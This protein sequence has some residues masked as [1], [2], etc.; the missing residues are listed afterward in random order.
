MTVRW[1]VSSLREVPSTA[2]RRTRL[3]LAALGIGL[4]LAWIAAE[5]TSGNS[6]AVIFGLFARFWGDDETDTD[7][8]ATDGEQTESDDQSPVTPEPDSSAPA[9]ETEAGSASETAE[10]KP[11][12]A[13]TPTGPDTPGTMASEETSVASDGG[14]PVTA[15]NST[16]SSPGGDSGPDWDSFCQELGDAMDQAADGDLT[17]QFDPDDAPREATQMVQ[18]FN[19]TLFS[20]NRNINFVGGSLMSQRWTKSLLRSFFHHESAVLSVSVSPVSAR[21]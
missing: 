18:N 16:D 10:S 19:E 13:P 17:V 7:G 20:I 2:T 11:T 9:E 3:G 5:P 15:D 4:C 8:E 12:E 6:S 21:R 14:A 1:S